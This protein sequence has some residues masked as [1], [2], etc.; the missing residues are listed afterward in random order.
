MH[1]AL[2]HSALS[3]LWSKCNQHIRNL[4]FSRKFR[5]RYSL[6][7]R[8]E[9]CGGSGRRR[10]HHGGD[11]QRHGVPGHREAEASQ[12]GLRLLRLRRR[13][14]VDAQGEPGGL[15]QDPVSLLESIRISWILPRTITM[16]R[17]TLILQSLSALINCVRCMSCPFDATAPCKMS[18]SNLYLVLWNIVILWYGRPFRSFL[19]LILWMS[20][21][22]CNLVWSG[23]ALAY[24]SMCPR[25]TWPQVFWASTSRCPLWLLPLPFRKWLTQ[26]VFSLTLLLP[27]SPHCI[28][29]CIYRWHQ[30]SAI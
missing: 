24:W 14:R 19:W 23:S 26:M 6:S 10:S 20:E 7:F 17:E 12:D 27:C 30:Y 22:D 4:K 13:G 21:P 11:H 25:L 29:D 16:C 3:S 18:V 9:W 1:G 5:V 28:L 2:L 8:R 15:L